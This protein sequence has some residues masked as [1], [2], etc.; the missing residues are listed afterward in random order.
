MQEGDMEKLLSIVY[1]LGIT[2][3][4]SLV[5]IFVTIGVIV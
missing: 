3:G 1:K 2:I 5:L 4:V